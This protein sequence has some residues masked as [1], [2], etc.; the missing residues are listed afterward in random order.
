MKTMAEIQQENEVLQIL[1]RD[2]RLTIEAL[3]QSLSD[4]KAIMRTY[5]DWAG[6]SELRI[7]R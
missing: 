6:V 7:V 2:Q 1:V 4:T 5:K 3:Q